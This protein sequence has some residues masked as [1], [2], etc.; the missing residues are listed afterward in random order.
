MQGVNNKEEELIL[1]AVSNK[2]DNSIKLR[3]S[4]ISSRCS[5]LKKETVIIRKMLETDKKIGEK[6]N[7]KYITN[8]LDDV[9][10]LSYWLYGKLNKDREDQKLVNKYIKEEF[11]KKIKFATRI[12]EM[13]EELNNLYEDLRFILNNVFKNN[14]KRTIEELEL[15]TSFDKAFI[16][17]SIMKLNFINR[18][19][20]FY[21]SEVG[22]KTDNADTLLNV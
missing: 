18:Y 17:R 6:Y 13:L 4:L 19:L 3:L 20:L 21:L 8:T 16:V 5:L 12:N 22:I 1:K 10:T 11:D 9:F 14:T 2:R 7:C 15:N